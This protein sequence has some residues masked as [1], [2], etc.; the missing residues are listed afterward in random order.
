M[1]SLK[2]LLDT[3]ACILYISG[4]SLRLRDKIAATS[5]A[6]ICVCSIVKAEMYYGSMKSV[7]PHKSL[8][9][10]NA[11]LDQFQSLPFNDE[12]ALIFGEI[13]SSLSG[14]GMPIGAYDMQIAAIALANDLTLVTHNT[15]EFSRVD[16]LKI[17][18]WEI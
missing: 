17:E 3:N 13:R 15:K 18:D 11:F 8:K 10:Q 16:D 12:A 1:Q 7:N 4:R 9:E 5:A 2:Y 6:Q 14:K